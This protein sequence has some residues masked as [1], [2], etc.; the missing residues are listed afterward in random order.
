MA[1]NVVGVQCDDGLLPDIILLTLCE[2]IGEQFLSRQP[3]M[4]PPKHFDSLKG[5]DAF[6]FF[7][8]QPQTTVPHDLVINGSFLEN[9]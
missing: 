5:L 4:F 2:S 7:F 1:I 8:K 6:R 9:T 3:I